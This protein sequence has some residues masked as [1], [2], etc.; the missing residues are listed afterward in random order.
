[1][2]AWKPKLR[3]LLPLRPW[4]RFSDMERR[5]DGPHVWSST[6][7]F[8]FCTESGKENPAVIRHQSE[9]APGRAVEAVELGSHR[10]WSCEGPIAA[11]LLTALS[12]V[13][14]PAEALEEQCS[15]PKDTRLETEQLPELPG[16]SSLSA[17]W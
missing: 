12:F 13:G 5:E 9:S 16:H 3:P 11:R 14:E 4:S 1:M 7:L 10:H 6:F 2:T 17:S 8:L 15:L